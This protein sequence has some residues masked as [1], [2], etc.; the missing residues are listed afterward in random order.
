MS[1]PA[2]QDDYAV[3]DVDDE[4]QLRQVQLAEAPTLFKLVDENREYLAKWLLWVQDTKDVSDTQAFITKTLAARAEGSAYQYGVVL[5]GT[6]IGHAGLMHITDGQ[7]PE[8]GYWIARTASGNGIATK[9]ASALTTL[10][11]QT[12]ALPLVIIRAEPANQA[13]NRIA[14]KLGYTP[15]ATGYDDGLS[16]VITTW[17]IESQ[18]ST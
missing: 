7:K 10:A 14:E 9:V 13:S 18:I 8:I 17:S 5:G 15:V 3:I 1:Q 11:L 12:L 4:L 16:R 6:L 2:Q